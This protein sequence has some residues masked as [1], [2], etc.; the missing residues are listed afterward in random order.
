MN[1]NISKEEAE[2]LNDTEE[3]QEDVPVFQPKA[4]AKPATKVVA[5]APVTKPKT[6]LLEKRDAPTK[7]APKTAPVA[8]KAAPAP[9]KKVVAVKK[10]S[11]SQ[12]ESQ[13]VSNVASRKSSHVE[14]VK[15]KQ[16]PSKAAKQVDPESLSASSDEEEVVAT[17][18]KP[19]A[20]AAPAKAAPAPVKTAPVKAVPV[21]VK[22]APVPVKT[23]PAPVKVA[24]VADKRV[25][26]TTVAKPTP[27]PVI[28]GKKEQQ[29]I[30]SESEI[31]EEEQEVEE[32]EVEQEE[33][34][35]EEVEEEEEEEIVPVKKPTPAPAKTFAKPAPTP[36]PAHKAP[37]QQNN[38]KGG[39]GRGETY[40]V[41]V[42]GIDYNANEDDINNHFAG[43]Q[44]FLSV[45]LITRD[46]GKHTGK[47][48]VKF[49]SQEGQNAALE[50]NYSKINGRDV[51]V[52]LPRA[53]GEKPAQQTTF[54]NNFN[55]SEGV[56]SES[57]SVIVR[58]LPFT[59]D[60]NKLHDH[61]SVCGNVK[62]V[63]I[64][65]KED[66]SSKGF[67][68]VDFYDVDSAKK[69]LLKSGNKLDN[70]QIDVQYSIPREQR[71]AAPQGNDRKPFGAPRGGFGRPPR[72]GAADFKK[73]LIAD[74]NMQAE[75][76]D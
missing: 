41:F 23:A 51:Y 17:T 76:L 54:R 55:Q 34:V 18:K 29:V 6:E 8:V 56:G 46:D 9:V 15:A 60:E 7:V 21:P 25:K 61:F 70:R 11:V 67:G 37:A 14:T 35:E 53:Q 69:A 36:A 38:Q 19:V 59:V 26:Q 64:I 12:A 13:V 48:F 30:K 10:E 20:K 65:L 72:G 62:N 2:L 47:C 3:E 49:A 33:E 52:S 31:E 1:K 45:K 58:N 39:Y 43:V 40:E 66:G 73:G 71:G 42:A 50:L 57:A 32:E 63:R 5:K 16:V 28:K 24:E 27:A 22:T 75:D 4:A 68:F 44:D 74:T